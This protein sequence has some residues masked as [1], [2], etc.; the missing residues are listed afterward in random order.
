MKCLLFTIF[1]HEV[2]SFFISIVIKGHYK[3]HEF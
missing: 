1:D 2:I 3:G